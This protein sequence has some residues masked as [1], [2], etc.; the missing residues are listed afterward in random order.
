MYK[1]IS[2]FLK[3]II[4]GSKPPQIKEEEVTPPTW[5]DFLSQGVNKIYAGRITRSEQ[6]EGYFG[7]NPFIRQKN[8]IVH[9]I[10]HPMPIPDNTISV[11][12]SE[13]V[14]EHVPYDSLVE[15]LNEIYRTLK[16]NGLFRLSLPD[17]RFDVYKNRSLKKDNGE[18]YFDPG[19]GGEFKDNQI[20]AGGHLWFPTYE[21]VLDLINRTNFESTKVNFLHYNTDRES[22]TKK[23]DYSLGFIVR[24]PDHDSRS[25]SPYRAMSIVVDLRK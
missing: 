23:I 1:V 20:I 10:Q 18:I 21:N 8:H 12:Q 15:V 22:I 14:F 25:Q 6:F 24:T 17:Y 3:Q 11:Y 13:D 9:D 16:P 19:G 5:E 4:G 2:T 7:L